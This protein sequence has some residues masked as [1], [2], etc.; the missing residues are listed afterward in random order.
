[1]SY[2]V[3]FVL[4][5]IEPFIDGI[6][7]TQH[8]DES[9]AVLRLHFLDILKFRSQYLLM[10]IHESFENFFFHDIHLIRGGMGGGQAP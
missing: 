10:E 4:E 9:F 1:M 2:S 7:M 6:K 3:I 5:P 8:I